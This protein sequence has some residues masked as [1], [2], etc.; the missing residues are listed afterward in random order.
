MF[1]KTPV[2][3]SASRLISDHIWEG[4]GLMPADRERLDILY[5]GMCY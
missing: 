3:Q 2:T 1:M 5:L 4:N